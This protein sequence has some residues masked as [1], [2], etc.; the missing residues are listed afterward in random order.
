[1]VGRRAASGL[2]Q[3]AP[4]GR[5]LAGEDHAELTYNGAFFRAGQRR[6]PLNDGLNR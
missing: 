6:L 3:C 1:M 2:R 4:S 5:L